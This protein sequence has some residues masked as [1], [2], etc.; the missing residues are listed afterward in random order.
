MKKWFWIAFILIIAGIGIFLYATTPEKYTINDS[1]TDI[2]AVMEERLETPIEIREHVKSGDRMF[3]L[4][5]TDKT[6]GMGEFSQGK[7]GKYAVEVIGHGSKPIRQSII[8]TNEG[9]Y[10]MVAGKN[11]NKLARIDAKIEHLNYDIS[12]DANK[13]YFLTLTPINGTQRAEATSLSFY[14]EK[15]KAIELK[16]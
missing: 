13:P 15:G 1:M 12:I 7:N 4:F 2:E 9:L 6:L 14:D 10:L 16:Y 5:E 11:E 8:E 3:V